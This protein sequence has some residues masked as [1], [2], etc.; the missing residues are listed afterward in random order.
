MD[1]SICMTQVVKKF[2]AQTTALVSTRNKTSNIKK[3]NRHRT[4]TLYAGAV[5]RPA[6]I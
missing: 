5:V 2:V 3:L 1:E 6:S 4:A